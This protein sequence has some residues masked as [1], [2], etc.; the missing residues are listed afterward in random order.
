MNL[1]TA[2]LILENS[3]LLENVRALVKRYP[4]LTKS[5][6]NLEMIFDPFILRYLPKREQF[7]ILFGKEEKFKSTAQ[8]TDF[9]MNLNLL[10]E[11]FAKSHPGLVIPF[12]RF[13]L[14]QK[15]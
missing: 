9:D 10:K 6:T 12:H 13:G 2:T 14:I 8:V 3:T 1:D 7:R 5:L 15:K 11:R 4:S